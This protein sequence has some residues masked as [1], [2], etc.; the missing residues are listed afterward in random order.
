MRSELPLSSLPEWINQLSVRKIID[1]AFPLN[2]LLQDCL[3]YPSSA[4]DGTPIQY[5]AGNFHSFI[6]VDYGYSEDQLK[7]AL[8][9]GF[10]G[11]D[12]IA[13]RSVTEAELVPSGWSPLPLNP[14]D[15]DP[16][17]IYRGHRSWIKSPFCNWSVF[18]RNNQIPAIHGPHR[19]SLLYLCADGVAAFQ[20][21]F[22]ANK[23]APK[24]VA[25]IQPGDGFGGNWTRFADPTAIFARSVLGNPHG[26]PDYLL[27][28]GM[29]DYPSSEGCCW[30]DYGKF[31][32]RIIKNGPVYPGRVNV[33][34]RQS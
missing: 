34:A 5:L 24:A 31:V 4:F 28:G 1:E 29:G 12:L 19:F 13:C 23:A 33:W 17:R 25:I 7:S 26:Q 27:Y 22:I 10:R 8:V 32:C 21:L 30:P 16:E 14:N 15:G 6:Y 20:A 11:Y 2:D 9:N 3:Y 18:Q